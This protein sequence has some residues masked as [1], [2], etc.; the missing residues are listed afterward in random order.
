[1]VALLAKDPDRSKLLKKPDFGSEYQHWYSQALRVVEQLLPDRYNEFRALHKDERRKRLDIETYG[2]AD[3]IGGYAPISFTREASSNRALACFRQQIDI[4]RTAKARLDSILTDIGRT[5]HGKILDDELE[6][7]KNLL[8]NTHVRSAGVI[9]GV[10][11]EGHL[12]K[13]IADHKVPFRKKA[14]LSNLNDTLRDAGVYDIPQWRRIQHLTDVRN[15]CGHKDQRE[16]K[17]EEVE[18]LI[19]EASKIIKTLF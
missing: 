18:D 1:M 19:S 6:E 4:V 16:P 10:A 14:M 13:L 9:A 17:R 15:I 12:K 5:V 3:Y 7:A 11:L 8:A 2:I